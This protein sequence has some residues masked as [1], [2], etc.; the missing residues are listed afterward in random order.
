ME[1]AESVD[2]LQS[3]AFSIAALAITFVA[4]MLLY[5]HES[6]PR[7]SCPHARAHLEYDVHSLRSARPHATSIVIDLR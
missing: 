3:L 7:H 4:T 6:E 2:G 5:V 1:Q